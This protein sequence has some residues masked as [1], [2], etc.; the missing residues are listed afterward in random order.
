MTVAA[1]EGVL[2]PPA[3]RAVDF[4]REIQPL[5]AERCYSCHGVD[6]QKGGLRLDRK[7]DALT[8]G[9]S[10]KVIAPGKS[11][12]SLLIQNVAGLDPD[13]LMP[14][15]GKGEPLSKEQIAVLRAWIDAGAA[16]PDELAAVEKSKH[17]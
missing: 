4:K 8:G 6:K 13:N 5:F 3:S 9:D 17:W 15:K 2:P 10:G 1:A 14:P 16:W 7:I 11:A 12:E